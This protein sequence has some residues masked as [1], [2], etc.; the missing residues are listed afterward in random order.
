MKTIIKKFEEVGL[1]VELSNKLINLKQQDAKALLKKFNLKTKDAIKV[2]TKY[3][4][5]IDSNVLVFSTDESE[6]VVFSGID[7]IISWYDAKSLLYKNWENSKSR[8]SESNPFVAQFRPTLVLDSIKKKLIENKV[9]KGG[10]L[11][12]LIDNRK[13]MV[14]DSKF[15]IIYIYL[16]HT[17]A[18]EVSYLKQKD[19]LNLFLTDEN[20]SEVYEEIKHFIESKTKF[21]KVL[22]S[23]LK[24]GFLKNIK[25]KK[26]NK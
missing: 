11:K 8:I 18:I 26:N 10:I 13:E 19:K 20:L 2:K 12:P 9:I 7:F 25:L 15:T 14:L 3:I 23:K 5:E 4:K 6:E 16:N 24:L 1:Q 21:R 17:E 22:L